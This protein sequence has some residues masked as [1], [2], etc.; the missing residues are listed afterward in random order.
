MNEKSIK[1]NQN[2]SKSI[3]I[4]QNQSKSI[5]INQ[6]QSKSIKINQKSKATLKSQNHHLNLFH[7][8]YCFQLALEE[9]KNYNTVHGRLKLVGLWY[10]E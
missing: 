9:V 2:Q 5:K 10:S 3:K 4:N 1:I 8:T 6:N 7:F